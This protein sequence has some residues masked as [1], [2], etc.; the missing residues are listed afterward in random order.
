MRV[1]YC[2]LFKRPMTGSNFLQL[3]TVYV[4]VTSQFVRISQ[5]ISDNNLWVESI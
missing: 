1:M 5:N 2:E 3:R 4:S